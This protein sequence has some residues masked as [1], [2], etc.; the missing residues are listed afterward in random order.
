MATPELLK[1]IEVG[2]DY[3]GDVT[4]DLLDGKSIEGFLFACDQ[5]AA[6]P[7]IQMYLKGESLPIK[8][9]VINLKEVRITGEDTAAGKS[10]EAWKA[11]QEAVKSSAQ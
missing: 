7:F 1:S 2:M 5:K 11:K 6:E 10:W 4:V 9:Q 8:I 3:R